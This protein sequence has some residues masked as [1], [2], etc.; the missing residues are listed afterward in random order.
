MLTHSCIHARRY[1]VVASEYLIPLPIST[2]SPRRSIRHSRFKLDALDWA[3][4][5]V[6]HEGTV[7][8]HGRVGRGRPPGR[9]GKQQG[10]R[11][12][13]AAVGS[14]AEPGRGPRPAA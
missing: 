5:A 9:L 4:A 10:L 8:G 11:S 2:I 7:R 1:A 6:G 13:T 3:A 12:L 14:P